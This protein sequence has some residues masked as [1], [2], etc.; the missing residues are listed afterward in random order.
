MIL[1]GLMLTAIWWYATRHN[2]LTD[3]HLDPRQRRSQFVALFLTVTLFVLSIAVT[4]LDEN[5]ARL[6]W[7]LVIPISRYGQRG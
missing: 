6:L 1:A 4:F 5:L 7:L 2:R 3:S